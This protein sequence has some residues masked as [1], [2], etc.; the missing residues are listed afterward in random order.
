MKNITVLTQRLLFTGAML[1]ACC[2]SSVASAQNAFETTLSILSYVRWNNV[3]SP[4][5]CTIDN[6]DAAKQ[7]STLARQN[8]YSFRIEAIQTVQL[9]RTH[10]DAAFFS[11]TNPTT[12]QQLINSSMNKNILSFSSSN[13]DCDIGSVFCLYTSRGGKTLFKLNIDSL[14]R[15]KMHVDPRVLLLARN[16]E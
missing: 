8:N 3:E 14:S 1:F 7:F 13:S 12:E 15:S 5:I 16:A 10:C 4:I 6:D 2:S 9:K 11:N